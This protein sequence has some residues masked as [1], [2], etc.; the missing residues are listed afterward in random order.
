MSGKVIGPEDSAT[1]NNSFSNKYLLNH[2]RVPCILLGA[3]D[4]AV[5]SAFKEFKA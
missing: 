3:G 2:H 5:V 1:Y 4:S